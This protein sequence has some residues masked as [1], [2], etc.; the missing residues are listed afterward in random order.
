MVRF[1]NWESVVAAL[2]L[3]GDTGPLLDAIPMEEM[4]VLIS[5]KLQQLIVNPK[6]PN[7]PVMALR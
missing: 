2:V 7:E 6:H 1:Q 5:P 4:D 3:P